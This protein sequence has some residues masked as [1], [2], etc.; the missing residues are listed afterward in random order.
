MIKVIQRLSA[1]VSTVPK[2]A[3][4]LAAGRGTRLQPFTDSVPKP[5]VPV[6]GVPTLQRILDHLEVAGVERVIVNAHHLGEQIVAFLAGRTSPMI[7][8]IEEE[9]LLETGGSVANALDQLGDEPFLVV[10]GDSVWLDGMSSSVAA[11]SRYWDEE[12]MDVLLQLH[13]IARMT[14]WQGK[15]DFTMDQEGRLARRE[16]PRVAPFAYMGLSILHPRIFKD[17]PEPPFSLNLLYDRAEEQGRL[18]GAVH[19]GL[20]YHI[21][22]IEDLEMANRRFETGHVPEVPFF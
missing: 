16:E 9:E 17:L 3:M 14:G 1:E 21:S 10:N 15:G 4:V 7:E 19:D 6:G 13:P 2:T 22:T 20:W 12:K 11:F 5:L 18:F 8:V